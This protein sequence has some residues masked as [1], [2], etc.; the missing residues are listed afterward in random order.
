M[1]TLVRATH[2]SYQCTCL[3]ISSVSFQ[4]LDISRRFPARGRVRIQPNNFLV[5]G[6]CLRAISTLQACCLVEQACRFTLIGILIFLDHCTVCPNCTD[7]PPHNAEPNS[8]RLRKNE[9]HSDANH[10]ERRPPGPDIK[11]PKRSEQ[12][13]E[14]DRQNF[15]FAFRLGIDC[16]RRTYQRSA[17]AG[18]IGEPVGIL[19]ATIITGRS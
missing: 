14:E 1:V 10:N 9:W 13:C 2:L 11:K 12:D 16:R 4:G 19:A 6:Y 3:S 18:A 8:S 7:D 17:T 15:R 5:S